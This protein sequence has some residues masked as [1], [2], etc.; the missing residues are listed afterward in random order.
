M[1]DDK[2]R[3]KF[4]G[5][6]RDPGEFGKTDMVGA[7]VGKELKKKA[8]YAL[9]IALILIVIYIAW[10]FEFKFGIAAILALVHDVL[11]T[12]GLI[13]LTGRQFNLPI[14]NDIDLASSDAKLG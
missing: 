6:L 12:A 14:R 7:K 4:K 11:I 3:E 2:L 13:A 1:I 10:R 9:A 5:L 8:V